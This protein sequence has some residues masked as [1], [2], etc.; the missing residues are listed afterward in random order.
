MQRMQCKERSALAE[1][2]TL[3]MKVQNRETAKK[4]ST[5][6]EPKSQGTVWAEETRAR[7]NKLTQAERRKLRDEGMK[8]YYACEPKPT[9]VGRG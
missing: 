9:I 3:F 6:A 4:P 5:K 8:L 7:C 1:A 2:T